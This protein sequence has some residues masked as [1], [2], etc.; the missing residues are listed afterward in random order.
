[1]EFTRN[2]LTQELGACGAQSRRQG[3]EPISRLPWL[4]DP[5]VERRTPWRVC[6]ECRRR[7][8]KKKAVWE[9]AG[10][11]EFLDVGRSF[12]FLRRYD[13]RSDRS[14][15]SGERKLVCAA[16]P[17][18]QFMYWIRIY[19]GIQLVRGRNQMDPLT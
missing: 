19:L 5:Q 8:P 12:K 4:R 13:V 3:P 10:L 6:P 17:S 7:V 15:R 1:M 2:T 18:K 9:L 11:L 14:P 16:R